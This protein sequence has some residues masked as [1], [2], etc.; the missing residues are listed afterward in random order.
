MAEPTQGH[1]SVRWNAGAVS[2]TAL[3]EYSQYLP[4][5]LLNYIVAVRLLMTWWSRVQDEPSDWSRGK[6]LPP[7]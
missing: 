1:H 2:E 4:S 6:L 3:P 7:R 5:H